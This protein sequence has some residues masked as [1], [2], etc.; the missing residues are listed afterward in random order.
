MF[1]CAASSFLQ[2]AVKANKYGQCIRGQQTAAAGLTNTMSPGELRQAQE[3]TTFDTAKMT[4]LL[5]HDNH[6]MRDRFR[7]FQQNPD[8]YMKPKYNISLA[9]ERE[10][11]LQRLQSVCDN[12]FISVLN[13]VDN[14]YKIFAAHEL[15]GI[16]DPSTCTKMTV[17]FNL[18][19]G[20]ILKL[21]TKRH[22]DKLLKGIDNLHDIGCFGLTELGYGNNAVEM[23]TT[24]TYDKATD[25]F[26]I[27]S[28][29]TL[30]QKYWI[31]NGA[32]HAKWIV[33]FAHLK[34]ADVNH[35]IHGFLVRIRDDDMNVLPGV[36]VEDMGIKIGLNGVDN[37]KLSFDHVRIPREHLLNKHSDV[38]ADGEFQS[39]IQ[40]ARQRFL[41]VADQL[42]SGRICIAAMS[43]GGTKACLA[44]AARYAATR[45]TVGPRGKSDMPIL[46][47]QLQQRALL[48]L[49]AQTYAI[50]LGVDYVKERW[51]EQPADG[52]QHAE[53]VTMCCAI[54]PMASWLFE[55]V[56][57]TCRERCGGAGYLA[58]NRFGVF[59]GS[60]HAAM[61]AEGDNSVLMQKVAKERLAVFKPSKPE[62][63]EVDLSDPASLHKLLVARENLT[64]G[65]LGMKLMKAGKAGLFDTWMLQE[66]DAVQAAARSFG[67]RLVSE[68]FASVIETQ[69]ALAGVLGQL[70]HL[71]L[72][73]VVEANLGHL[74]TSGLLHPKV[75]AGVSAAA[76]QLCTALG[77]HTLQLVEAFGIPEE[78]LS[79]PIA[80]DWVQY[81]A[82]DNQGEV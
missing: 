10:V 29:T 38:T 57:T 63:F 24:S 65:A 13:F 62:P 80:R 69:P 64:F 25:E 30:A 5:D 35:G 11:A 78:M 74:V 70:Y 79:A 14:P 12:D 71:H 33:V 9:E 54:K 28:P 53:V 37:A 2:Q 75:G 39:S 20:T 44:I 41:T 58:C 45:L 23:E 73:S 18:F 16:I 67:D 22:H 36:T 59:M 7:R 60:A 15:V 3:A 8:T 19:G 77:P 51:A 17:Q 42:L 61:T 66:S 55:K 1:R 31:T 47:Y 68:R 72:L 48:P 27:H 26:I 82:Y 6:D 43:V 40:G 32:I 4:H 56:V 50:N 76:A 21:G 52:S 34:M 49:L 81:N 46:S